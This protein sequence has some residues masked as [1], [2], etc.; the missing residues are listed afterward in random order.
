M[1]DGPARPPLPPC[2]HRGVCD[3]Q[4]ARQ[5]HT[6]PDT[7]ITLTQE[8]GLELDKDK[9]IGRF[10]VNLMAPLFRWARG[11]SFAEVTEDCG[12]YEGTLIR[13]ARRLMELLSQVRRSCHR[14]ASVQLISSFLD[15][16]FH[17]IAGHRT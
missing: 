9:Y 17:I 5:R 8:C 1:S 3:D 15:Q 7:L 11:A 6:H 2:T 12:I 16:S 10:T 14:P 13:G 4:G